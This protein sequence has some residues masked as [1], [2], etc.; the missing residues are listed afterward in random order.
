MNDKILQAHGIETVHDFGTIGECP[1][2]FGGPTGTVDLVIR[3]SADA[4]M[5]NIVKTV[6]R[7]ANT[8]R[9]TASMV[10]PTLQELRGFA[11]NLPV[12]PMSILQE[13]PF[14]PDIDQF[15]FFERWLLK[16]T[17]NLK[18]SRVLLDFE[19]YPNNS[20]RISVEKGR[21]ASLVYIK[22]TMRSRGRVDSTSIEITPEIY[23]TIRNSICSIE[24]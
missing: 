2:P 13:R 4:G 14:D 11:E 1:C 24:V 10:F 18:N 23:T 17:G 8:T 9:R 16:L 22:S 5:A 21:K 20:L 6:K 12:D 15:G 7:K 3:K 19:P